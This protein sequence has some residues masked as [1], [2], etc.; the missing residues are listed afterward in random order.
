MTFVNSPPASTALDSAGE[1][2]LSGDPNRIATVGYDGST[3]VVDLRESGSAGVGVVL[4]ERCASAL[5]PFLRSRFD[6]LT[7]E[8]VRVASTY[9]AAFCPQSGCVYADDQDDRIRAYFLK[10]AEFG[11]S[12]RIGAHRGTVWVRLI[13]LYERSQP[14]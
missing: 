9:T 7:K 13:Q 10:S 8:R 11:S 12:K 3:H 14:V 4:H 6:R 2:D 1:F 5:L